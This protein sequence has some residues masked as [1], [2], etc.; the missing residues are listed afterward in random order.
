MLTTVQRKHGQKQKKEKTI[1]TTTQPIFL[2][3]NI[4]DQK[5]NN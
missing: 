4:N 1:S 5:S 2:E 3:I